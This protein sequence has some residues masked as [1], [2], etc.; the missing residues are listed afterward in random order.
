MKPALLAPYIFQNKY[1]IPNV[2][3]KGALIVKHMYVA[4]LDICINDVIIRHWKL[5]VEPNYRRYI[6]G[7][8]IW[9]LDRLCIP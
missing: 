2:W 1:L 5:S 7:S 3:H 9:L 6:I 4:I 8:F